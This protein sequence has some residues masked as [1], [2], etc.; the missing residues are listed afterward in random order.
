[1]KRIVMIALGALLGAA[2]AGAQSPAPSPGPLTVES[3]MAEVQ[4]Q[5]F[6]P[7]L[8]GFDEKLREG[9]ARGMLAALNEMQAAALGAAKRAKPHHDADEGVN[10]LYTPGEFKLF[11]Q[12]MSGKFGGVGIKIGPPGGPGTGTPEKG[13]FAVLD[14]IENMPAVK[15]GVKK[16]DLLVSVDSVPV[17]T[18]PLPE[19]VLKLRGPAASTVKIGLLRDGKPL[20]VELVR[21]VVEWKA[22]VLEV[23]AGKQYGVLTLREFNDRAS[24]DLKAALAE[25]TS[26]KLWGLVLDLRDNPGG[27][28]DVGLEACR[29]FLDRGQVIAKM[30]RRGE[31]EKVHT[32]EGE[33]LYRG[34]LVLLVNRKTRSSAELFAGALQDNKKALV[35][36]ERTFGKGTAETVVSLPGGYAMKVTSLVLFRPSGASTSLGGLKPDVPCSVGDAR[37]EKPDDEPD[38]AVGAATSILEFARNKSP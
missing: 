25:A 9:A 19:I 13:P 34:T 15:A 23:P 36:G 37:D 30:K 29:M 21:Q 32:Q 16:G 12:E 6:A 2:S 3:V 33:P 17:T 14:T 35:V 10:R 20:D 38:E 28:L 26:K 5:Y 4:R 7:D 24:A 18:V 22:A 1:M 27:Q 8:P 11:S 31:P